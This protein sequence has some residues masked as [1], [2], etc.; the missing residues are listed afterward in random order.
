MFT[1]II[2]NLRKLVFFSF[3]PVTNKEAEFNRE[4]NW[5]DK[6]HGKVHFIRR[7]RSPVE[8]E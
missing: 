5:L 4:L 8:S 1:N 3:F 7:I 2:Q 6:G